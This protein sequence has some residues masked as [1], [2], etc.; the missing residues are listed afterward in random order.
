MFGL[1]ELTNLRDDD[2]GVL[3][4]VGAGGFQA[5]EQ[6]GREVPRGDGGRDLGLAGHVVGLA[7]NFGGEGALE[8]GT[9]GEPFDLGGGEFF[10]GGSFFLRFR[11]GGFGGGFLC[12]GNFFFRNWL[13]DWRN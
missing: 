6:A 1:E 11:L 10:G 2:R 7:K 13:F 4:V 5:G 8:F 12:G 3:A 9:V